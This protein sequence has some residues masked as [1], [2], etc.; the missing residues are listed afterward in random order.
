MKNV[1]KGWH[2][3]RPVKQPLEAPGGRPN[4][5]PCATAVA[6]CSGV[7]VLPGWE[8]DQKERVSSGVVSTALE[9]RSRREL[10]ATWQTALMESMATV[11]AIAEKATEKESLE[12]L[13]ETQATLKATLKDLG[14]ELSA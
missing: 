4:S 7:T 3:R 12:S 2:A 14:L 1:F 10:R 9:G 8:P 13:K 5:R 11:E 6:K